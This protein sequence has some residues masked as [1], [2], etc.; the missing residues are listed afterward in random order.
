METIFESG[1]ATGKYAKG[2]NEALG[3]PEIEV[4]GDS[5]L[6]DT[7]GEDNTIPAFSTEEQ[8]ASSSATRPRKRAKVVDSDDDPLVS[9]IASS[10]ERLATALEKLARG[11]MDLPGDLYTQLTSL[12]GFSSV[13]IS[14]YY[15]HLVAHPHIGRAFYNLPLEARMDW[16]E[17]F[18]REKF[19]GS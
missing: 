1:M 19:P 11:D 5:V 14:S 18:I 15:S 9:V 16:I 10:S 12:P 7:P 6:P 2:S 3:V 17:E 8:G 13:H 4:D